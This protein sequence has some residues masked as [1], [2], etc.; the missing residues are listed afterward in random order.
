MGYKDFGTVRCLLFLHENQ[1]AKMWCFVYPA[2]EMQTYHTL[3]T[4]SWGSADLER[5][6]RL[7]LI[8][9]CYSSLCEEKGQ[10]KKQTETD[11]HRTRDRVS[12]GE[13]KKVKHWGQHKP[14]AREKHKGFCTLLTG[15]RIH[16]SPHVLTSY[17][18]SY[19]EKRPQ[20]GSP[21][22]RS[23]PVVWN[24]TY[25]QTIEKRH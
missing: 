6:P 18:A 22:W 12:E 8:S 19:K 10:R 13:R 2:S 16:V 3:L 23:A 1:R 20:L 11:L 7:T 9:G 14:Q 5:R 4:G 21:W 24:Q 25:T 17:A 15:C